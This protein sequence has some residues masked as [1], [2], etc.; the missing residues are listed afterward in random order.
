MSLPTWIIDRC[1]AGQHWIYRTGSRTLAI[2]FEN[3]FIDFNDHVA[4][5]DICA[6]INSWMW[7]IDWQTTRG[8]LISVYPLLT[9][10][11]GF[12]GGARS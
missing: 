5:L 4:L 7:G 12:L 9:A 6:D 11:A 2:G 1:L 8:R 3:G 10:F